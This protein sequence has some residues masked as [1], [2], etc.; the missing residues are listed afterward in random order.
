VARDG[1]VSEDADDAL[2]RL[3]HGTAVTAAIQEK[4]PDADLLI[5]RVFHDKLAASA[6]ALV[7]AIAWCVEQKVDLINLSLGSTNE[8]HLLAFQLAAEHALA[9]G[10][11][12]VAARAVGD[13]PCFPGSLPIVLGVGLD[14]DCPRDRFI[15]QEAADGIAYDASG[16]PR[17]IDGAP[18]HR[19][20]HGISFAVAQMSGFAALACQQIRESGLGGATDVLVRRQLAEW[21][22]APTAA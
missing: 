22:G 18:Q 15:V 17:P 5:V 10:T 12:L 2:D 16:Y 1:S 6:A 21:G 7:G 20:L 13:T 8:A 19:N 14:W 4:A 11:L 3:G 9:R